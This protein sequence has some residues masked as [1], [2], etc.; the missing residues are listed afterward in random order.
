LLIDE[1]LFICHVELL[2]GQLRRFIE[3]KF[4]PTLI[5]FPQLRLAEPRA[6]ESLKTV[7]ARLLGQLERDHKTLIEFTVSSAAPALAGL[8]LS[9][10]AIY[11]SERCD[12]IVID[13]EFRVYSVSAAERTLMQFSAPPEFGTN[14][15]TALQ[16]TVQEWSNRIQKMS[17]SQQENWQQY[18]RREISLS[19]L[20][21]QIATQNVSIMSL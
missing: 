18:I 11:Y 3:E 8:L 12:E 17:S 14:V 1:H 13:Q 6:L 10:T 15:E 20:K 4:R 16:Q 5:D 21:I 2:K 9:Y 7:A 19:P